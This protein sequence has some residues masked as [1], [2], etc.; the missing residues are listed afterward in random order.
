MLGMFSNAARRRGKKWLR[1]YG[2]GGCVLQVLCGVF[3]GILREKGFDLFQHRTAIYSHQAW[4]TLGVGH[5]VNNPVR[6]RLAGTG[7]R[8]P[9]NI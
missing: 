7:H 1:A 2:S 4:E 3:F 8:D 5:L 6:L 9:E